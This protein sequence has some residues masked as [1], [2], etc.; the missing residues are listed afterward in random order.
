MTESGKQG[1]SGHAYGSLAILATLLCICLAP[2]GAQTYSVLHNFGAGQDGET[3]FA[4]LAIDAHGN[5]YGT[6]RYGGTYDDG[7]VFRLSPT[8]SGWL[9]SSLLQFNGANGSLPSAP[10]IFGP[11]GTLYGTTAYGGAGSGQGTVFNLRPQPHFCGSVN[12][13][14]NETLLKSFSDGDGFYPLNLAFDHAGNLYGVTQGGGYSGQ[15]VAFELT[16]STGSWVYSQIADFG[17][18]GVSLPNGVVPDA[19]GNLY[20]TSVAYP[21]TIFEITSSGQVQV[22]VSFGTAGAGI[23]PIS[24]L[25]MDG[26]GNLYGQTLFEGAGGGGAVFRYS[27]SQQ[28]LTVL[29]PFVNYTEG[30]SVST[31]SLMMDSQG[32]IYGTAPYQGAYNYGQVFKLTPDG[33][34]SYSYTDLHD[35]TCG[36]DGCGPWSNVVMDSAGN[37]Y[38]TAGYGG[39]NHYGVVWKITP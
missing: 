17:G 37:L 1:N 35:F 18:T 25:L 19:S 28:A 23:D 13:S 3:P 7:M 27:I 30:G 15:G 34:G 22:L 20:G 12:C 2:A 16:R 11:D 9:Y 38:G 24:Q 8:Q 39:A 4:G 14:W 26:A 29:Y 33:T 31:S 36:D 5:L 32:N 21:G 6:T 10:V